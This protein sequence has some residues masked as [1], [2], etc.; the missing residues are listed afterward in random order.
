MQNITIDLKL[1]IK[2][3]WNEMYGKIKIKYLK[4]RKIIIDYLEEYSERYIKIIYYS[5]TLDN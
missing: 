5:I 1:S 3:L 2:G 4:I